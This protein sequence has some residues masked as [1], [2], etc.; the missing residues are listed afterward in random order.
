[1]ENNT[2]ASSNLTTSNSS[3]LCEDA[4]GNNYSNELHEMDSNHELQQV[5][6]LVP[7]VINADNAND[8]P[9]SD[10][11]TPKFI[12]TLEIPSKVDCE[13]VNGKSNVKE[14][15]Q[16][17][18]PDEQT[19]KKEKDDVKTEVIVEDIITSQ[20]PPV[21]IV[22]SP[23]TIIMYD[24]PPRINYVDKDYASK[25]AKAQLE[26]ITNQRGMAKQLKK[27]NKTK[28]IKIIKSPERK[29]HVR[30]KIEND[31]DSSPNL[32]KIKNSPTIEI[33]ENRLLTSNET[34]ILN[35][36]ANNDADNGTEIPFNLLDGHID[37]NIDHIVA[38]DRK[39][40]ISTNDDL[41]AFL[42]GDDDDNGSVE[43]VYETSSSVQKEE[44]THVVAQRILNFTV[45]KPEPKN[46]F[47]E[48]LVSDW[49]D[50][51]G[52]MEEDDEILVKPNIIQLNDQI[53][54]TKSST[55][56]HAN[57]SVTIARKTPTIVAET[58]P[59][60]VEAPI[61]K[62][63]RI[64]KK[65]IIWDPDAPET[66][67]SYSSLVQS[68]EAK[69]A[70]AKKALLDKTPPAAIEIS[71]KRKL[72][73]NASRSVSPATTGK[74]KKI[75]EVD[76][77]LM[78]EGAANMLN[79]LET[80]KAADQEKR[81]RGPKTTQRTHNISVIN[82]QKN[83]KNVLTI[84]NIKTKSRKEIVLPKSVTVKS[85]PATKKATTAKDSSKVDNSWDYIYT[86]TKAADDSMIIRRRSNSSYSS[87]NSQRRLSL[88][89]GAAEI[90][91]PPQPSTSIVPATNNDKATSAL[92]GIVEKP[93]RGKKKFEFVKPNEKKRAINTTYVRRSRINLEKD[94]LPVVTKLPTVVNTNRLI[95]PSVKYHDHFVE[96]PLIEIGR[97]S[98]T[99]CLLTGDRMKELTKIFN[100]LEND[101]ECVAVLI[102]SS[103]TGIFCSGL[104]LS[105]LREPNIESR[106]AKATDLLDSLHSFLLTITKF[107]KP[108]IAGVKGHV[109]NIGLVLLSAFDIVVADHSAFFTTTYA[110]DALFPEGF[111]LVARTNRFNDNMVSN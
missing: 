2:S 99:G 49:S 14:I 21:T 1:M 37:D 27:E 32:L 41:I 71:R 63:S 25:M 61:F 105:T 12:L 95:L 10:D 86:N 107:P 9:L 33:I 16:P 31:D 69:K 101:N 58:K 47:I 39:E 110:K 28:Q 92:S 42:E 60:V 26:R 91:T 80:S 97:A 50:N 81:I 53:L 106:K 11:E 35:S 43:T 104:D 29:L 57:N 83:N 66:Q 109:K 79:S 65:K 87:S 7:V 52:K 3:L 8:H 103:R 36:S 94:K 40:Q 74:K 89:I 22:T 20:K 96:F 77:L 6:A 68:S 90:I 45:G 4:G 17:V 111:P 102:Q 34:V 54:P 82:D 88:D 46:K 13:K 100:S 19:V 55:I 84:S 62:R 72:S 51:E 85:I 64:I 48:A 73:M 18:T 15:I 38:N 23:K 93:T 56:G 59:I 44:K 108:I 98:E 70:A 76:K 24:P 78:D 67:I 75:S 30:P 5:K